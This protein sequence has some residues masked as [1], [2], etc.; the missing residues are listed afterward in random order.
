MR[1]N[2][3][4]SKWYPS[5]SFVVKLKR[6]CAILPRELHGRCGETK[7]QKRGKFAEPVWLLH[8]D[9]GEGEKAAKNWGQDPPQRS[10]FLSA[11]ANLVSG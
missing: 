8:G 11:V 3:A 7:W 4:I 1:R 10:P 6:N 9:L 5:G 2:F